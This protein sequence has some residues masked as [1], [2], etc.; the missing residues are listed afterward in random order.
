MYIHWLFYGEGCFFY[1]WLTLQWWQLS[2]KLQ[3]SSSV[4]A[5]QYKHSQSFRRCNLL[6]LASQCMHLLSYNTD[7]S[8]VERKK[9]RENFGIQLASEPGIRGAVASLLIQVAARLKATCSWFQVPFFL[10]WLV[11]LPVVNGDILWTRLWIWDGLAVQA[12]RLSEC[13]HH[14]PFLASL[15]LNYGDKS[16]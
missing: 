4:A 7:V 8:L 12:H 14:P 5:L 9:P 16:V 11:T 10:S 2:P 15:W 6:R 13:S 1:A 3:A